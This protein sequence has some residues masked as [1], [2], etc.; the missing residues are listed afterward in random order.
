MSDG[1]LP[2]KVLIVDDDENVLN[3]IENDLVK[4]NI[5]VVKAKNWQTALYLF[6]QHQ[7]IEACIVLWS[8]QVY[9]DL[10]LFKNGEPIL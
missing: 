8:F 6:N 3:T 1:D 2:G 10:F 5:V 9:L 4:K 7:H